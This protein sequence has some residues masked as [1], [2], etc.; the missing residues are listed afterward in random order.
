M[1]A[2]GESAWR[3]PLIRRFIAHRIPPVKVWRSK[4][5]GA[6]VHHVVARV[7]H[8]VARVHHVIARTKRHLIQGAKRV[9]TGSTADTRGVARVT[10]VDERASRRRPGGARRDT[11]RSRIIGR[12]ISGGEWSG[13]L[14]LLLGTSEDIS[15]LPLKPSTDL[16]PHA[17]PGGRRSIPPPGTDE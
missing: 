7:H 1:R 17:S 3:H 5:R 4:T 9:Q 16:D 2:G 14:W 10:R 6:R 13:G 12:R 8:A 15:R 11:G